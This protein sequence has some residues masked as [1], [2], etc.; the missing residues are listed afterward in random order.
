MIILY[1]IST[2]PAFWLQATTRYEE[3]SICDVTP[4][5]K[6]SG[7][8]NLYCYTGE[9]STL[10]SSQIAKAFFSI[11][12]LSAMLISPGFCVWTSLGTQ[13]VQLHRW[14]WCEGS[15]SV[16]N[17][18][19]EDHLGVTDKCKP[20][21]NAALERPQ[22]LEAWFRKGFAKCLPG[23]HHWILYW[24]TYVCSGSHSRAF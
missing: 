14:R 12:S 9:T 15:K 10:I 23:R 4:A 17:R 1:I 13:K 8:L 3:V 2:A 11:L 7:I 18:G 21:S 24:V 16:H 20:R 5:L 19:S 22:D 6:V